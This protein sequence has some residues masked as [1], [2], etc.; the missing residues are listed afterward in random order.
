MLIGAHVSTSGGLRTALE[1]GAS[2]GADVVQIFTRSPR[3]WRSPPHGADELAAY[4]RDQEGTGAV[5]ATFCHATYLINL[6]TSD[7]ELLARSRDCL[8][9]SL[10]VATAIGAS[11]VVLHA[12]S[13]RGVGFGAVAGQ[14]ADE[15][16]RALDEAAQRVAREAA[17]DGAP[18]RDRTRAGN[19][20]AAGDGTATGRGGATCPLLL[21]NAAGAGGT[22]GRTFEELR[23][24]LDRAGGDRRLGICLDTQHLFASGI[25]YSS[26]Q[27]A[28]EVVRS[29]DRSVGLERLG[30]IH[31]NDSKVT[32]GA[33]RDRHENLGDGEIGTEGLAC[34]LG[35]PALSRVP[36]V[37]EVPGDGS[38][39]RAADVVAARRV[40]ARGLELRSA[41]P[42]QRSEASRRSK[43]SGDRSMR[44]AGDEERPR[45]RRAREAPT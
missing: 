14:V 38:G 4:R 18:A 29:I 8:V 36:A 20:P 43:T 17:A 3:A 35:H 10:A 27:A 30:C 25:D 5:R 37:L 21:E 7:A 23:A 44:P 32:F 22:V 39:P 28:D 26:V 40:L 33:N 6:A 31:L 42:S 34:L 16:L 9:D 13:H 1:R 19:S 45:R 24:L 11:G 15:L 41:A 12:G 2:I